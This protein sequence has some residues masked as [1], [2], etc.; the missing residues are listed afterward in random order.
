[1]TVLVEQIV[2]TGRLHQAEIDLHN[3]LFIE[4]DADTLAA[5]SRAA[6]RLED[7]AAA[8][9]AELRQAATTAAARADVLDR[10]AR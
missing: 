10:V 1:M 5:A 2:R 9:A 7:R 4:A 3:A 8:L 6:A